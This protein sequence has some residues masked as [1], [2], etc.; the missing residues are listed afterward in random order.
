M[1]MKGNYYIQFFK[2]NCMGFFLYQNIFMISQLT[3][4]DH[5]QDASF[6][7]TDN[8]A[9]ELYVNYCKFLGQMC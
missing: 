1:K 9:W 3:A 5:M 8:N 2:L 7:K 4:K 6:L